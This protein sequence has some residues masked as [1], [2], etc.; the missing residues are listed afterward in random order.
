MDRFSQSIWSTGQWCTRLWHIVTRNKLPASCWCPITLALDQS[1]EWSAH[2][3]GWNISNLGSSGVFQPSRQ[4]GLVQEILGRTDQVVN[5]HPEKMLLKPILDR[6]APSRH[7][8][9]CRK[10]TSM[11]D[12]PWSRPIFRIIDQKETSL[13]GWTHPM[14]NFT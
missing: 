1:Q 6:P 13:R 9:S 10:S 2:D 4:L 14:R 8:K 5:Y 3:S 11:A 7:C 12:F